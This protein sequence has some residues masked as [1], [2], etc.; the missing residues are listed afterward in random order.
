[1]SFQLSA[2]IL[3]VLI[4]GFSQVSRGRTQDRKNSLVPV[5]LIVEYFVAVYPPT[6]AMPATQ[7]VVRFGGQRFGG[8]T[9]NQKRATRSGDP[10]TCEDQQIS[11]FL[12]Q[13]TRY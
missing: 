3:R 5:L 11:C 8:V 7:W 10:G 1:M 4:C 6:R 13:K 9:S 12:L 2:D